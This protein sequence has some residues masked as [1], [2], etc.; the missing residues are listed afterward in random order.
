M[1]TW[2]EFGKTRSSWNDRLSL[3]WFIFL[4]KVPGESEYFAVGHFMMMELGLE[5]KGIQLKYS[6]GNQQTLAGVC[7]CVCN[8]T[9]PQNC[10]CSK[11]CEYVEC[12]LRYNTMNIWWMRTACKISYTLDSGGYAPKRTE[13]SLAMIFPFLYSFLCLSA[14]Y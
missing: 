13:L 3:T 7:G 11:L 4:A 8:T 2:S 10:R 9:N 14:N 1:V 5:K 6:W 12:H